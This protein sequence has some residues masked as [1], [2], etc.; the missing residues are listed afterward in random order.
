[1]PKTL[2]RFALLLAITAV[3]STSLHLLHVPAGI[4]LGALAAGIIVAVNNRAIHIPHLAFTFVQTVIGCLVASSITLDSLKSIK[5]NWL[6]FIAMVVSV[7]IVSSLMGWYLTQKRLFPGTTAVWGTSPGA[8]LIMT[9]MS[10]NFGGDPRLVAFMQY[11]RVTMVTLGASLVAWIWGTTT[12]AAAQTITANAPF[13]YPG[14]AVTIAICLACTLSA[15]AL[16]WRFAPTLLPMALGTAVNLS[17]LSDIVLP[18][19][20]YAGSF[21]VIGWSIGLRFTREILRH[22]VNLLPLLV[23]VFLG[24]MLLCAAIGLACA[25]VMEIDPFTAY[26]AT[27][28]G[29]MDAVAIIAATSGG[30]ASFVMAMQTTRF[31]LVTLIGPALASF[32]ARKTMKNE[33]E[34]ENA[35]KE[36]S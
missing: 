6:L 32:I 20:L 5:N 19:W 15:V 3:T 24:M 35:D 22:A 28:P 31:I 27:S 34:T 11:L 2:S 4:L 29:G 30:D 26:L 25:G 8:A 18:A 36:Q 23:A 21:I 16:N 17:G 33:C 9:I 1:M 13:D 10:E 12:H 14:F 7:I